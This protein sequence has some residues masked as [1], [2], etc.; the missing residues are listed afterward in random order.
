M[1]I[2]YVVYFLG[3]GIVIKVFVFG[4]DMF[5]L[6]VFLS[7]V[8]NVNFF[9]KG[10]NVVDFI[11]WFSDKIGVVSL[12][13]FLDSFKGFMNYDLGKLFGE[14]LDSVNFFVVLVN[15]VIVVRIIVVV[16]GVVFI[17]FVIVVFFLMFDVGK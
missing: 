10:M 4:S 13:G 5:F 15:G 1:N 2:F 14:V 8:L 17:G 9:L 7:K 12:G 16:I 6:F 11:S 3:V